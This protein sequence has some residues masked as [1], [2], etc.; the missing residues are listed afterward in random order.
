MR[1]LL[2]Q[3][4]KHDGDPRLHDATRLSDL[5]LEK[6]E[7][8]RVQTM[9][10]VPRKEREQIIAKAKANGRAVTSNEVYQAGKVHRACHAQLGV[11]LTAKEQLVADAYARDPRMA[12]DQVVK[13]TGT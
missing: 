4:P 5:G 10:E 3:M 12:V 1:E 8:Y 6:T 11:R 2:K 7:S 9:A 13:E